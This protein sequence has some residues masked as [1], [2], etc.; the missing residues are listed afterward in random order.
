L[1]AEVDRVNKAAFITGTVAEG[2]LDLAPA[3][4]LGTFH[5]DP[6]A[7]PTLIVLWWQLA[8]RLL[9]DQGIQ[10]GRSGA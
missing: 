1:P 9:S 6:A 5:W 8:A 10:C 7:V 4:L 3:Y 2:H